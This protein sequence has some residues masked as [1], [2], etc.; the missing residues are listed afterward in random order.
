M[1]C[2]FEKYNLHHNVA[3]CVILIFSIFFNNVVCVFSPW[4]VLPILKPTCNSLLSLQVIKMRVLLV[5]FISY[6][7]C[8]FTAVLRG[9]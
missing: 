1:N 8:Q 3:G 2:F 6:I 9:Y 5:S 7:Y 4:H